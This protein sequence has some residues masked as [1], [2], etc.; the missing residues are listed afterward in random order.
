MKGWMDICGV[1]LFREK[2]VH[3]FIDAPQEDCFVFLVSI[4]AADRFLDLSAADTVILF[5]WFILF[6]NVHDQPSSTNPILETRAIN[7]VLREGQKR[8]ILVFTLCTKFSIEQTIMEKA[9]LKSGVKAQ[10][11]LRV[12]I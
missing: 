8:E 11:E 12:N 1:F 10:N 2:A 5:D 6:F 7:T 4:K 9:K 3:R